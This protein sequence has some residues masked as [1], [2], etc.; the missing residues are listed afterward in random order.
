[1]LNVVMQS[2]VMTGQSSPNEDYSKIKTNSAMM[3][4]KSCYFYRSWNS[5]YCNHI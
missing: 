2:A 4:T 5:V 3:L 1:M